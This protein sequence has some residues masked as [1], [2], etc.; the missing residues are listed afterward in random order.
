MWLSLGGFHE[1]SGTGKMFNTHVIVSGHGEIV[2][3]CVCACRSAAASHIPVW[4]SAHNCN[5]L[6]LPKDSFI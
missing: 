3:R 5:S 6:Q 2:A 4:F 1:A